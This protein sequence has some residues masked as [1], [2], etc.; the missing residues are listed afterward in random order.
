MCDNMH[1]LNGVVRYRLA[2]L[3]AYI[4]KGTVRPTETAEA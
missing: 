1:G 3:M 2:D 4:D